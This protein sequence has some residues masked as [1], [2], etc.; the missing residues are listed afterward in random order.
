[1]KITLL[2]L[3]SLIVM[4]AWAEDAAAPSVSKPETIQAAPAPETSVV[5]ELKGSS[6]NVSAV[7]SGLEKEAV[8]KDAACSTAN[9]KSG[10]AARI[11]CTKADSALM[12]FLT[13]NAPAKV[14]WSISPAGCPT[15]C[16]LMPCPSIT[17]CCSKTTHK[18]C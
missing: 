2:I 15:G 12:T 14:Q 3:L 5:I 1:M 7:A 9:N 10:K 18:P 4:P 8:Y 16:L 11:T 17:V 6:K 13:K